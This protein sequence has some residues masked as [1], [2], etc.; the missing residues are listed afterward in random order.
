MNMMKKYLFMLAAFIAATATFTACSSEEDVA[1]EQEQT[2]GNAIRAQFNISIPMS[3]SG[4]TRQ[5]ASVVQANQDIA[6]FRGINDIKLYPSA[7]LS[8]EFGSSSKIIGRNI[9]LSKLMLP[10]ITSITP[11]TIP[12]TTTGR[13][14][15]IDKSFSVLYGDVQLQIGA[16]TFLFYGSAI[17]EGKLANHYLADYTDDEKIANGHLTISGLGDTPSDVS[18]FTFTPTAITTSAK[19]DDKRTAICAYLKKIAE[20]K[21]TIGENTVYWGGAENTNAGLKKLFNDF[22]GQ[23]NSDPLVMA[24]S[25]LNLQAE[26]EDLYFALVD[27][28]NELAVEICKN[29]N[30]NNYV[31]ITNTTTE[32]KLTFK[33]NISGYPSTTDNLPDGAAAIS[34]TISTVESK[35]VATPSYVASV[36]YTDGKTGVPGP[37]ELNVPNIGSYAYPACLYYY[38]KSGILTSETSQQALFDGNNTWATIATESNFENG[39]AITSKTRSV[40]LVDPVNYGVGRLDISVIYPSGI[41][42]RFPTA[43]ATT[44]IPVTDIKLTGILIGGQR[45]VDWQFLQKSG[46]TEYTIYDNITKS[47]TNTTG[48]ALGGPT[49]ASTYV[50]RTLVLESAGPQGDDEDNVKIALEFINNGDDFYGTQGLVRKG[51]KFYLVASLN[52]GDYKSDSKYTATGGKVFKQDYVTKAQFTVQSLKN[53]YNTIPDLRNPKVELGLSVDLQWSEGITFSVNID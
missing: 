7:A 51:T 1:E 47:T 41:A 20:T 10:A 42:E 37:T 48:I 12:G 11:N 45:A 21:A 18:G 15:L 44:T 43:V 38:G 2:L 23:T 14:G 27:N 13:D 22:T 17:A 35:I 50:N 8:T 4:T 36:T 16:R 3:Q 53:A 26:I 40:V 34:W 28:T 29:I 32:K 24:G 49:T 5:S 31:T 33:D 6:S 19:S 9:A 52:A 30:D 46:A 39:N 25:S